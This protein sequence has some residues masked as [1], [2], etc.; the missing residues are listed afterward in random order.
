MDDRDLPTTGWSGK[1]Y[2]ANSVD[3]D[4]T[5]LSGWQDIGANVDATKKRLAIPLDTAGQRFRY[6]LVWITK[7]P[8]SGRVGISEIVLFRAK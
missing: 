4:A 5:D 1:V 6:Y 2:V 8:P 3:A 7:L